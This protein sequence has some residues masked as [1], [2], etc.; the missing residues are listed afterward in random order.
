[1]VVKGGLSGELV[2]LSSRIQLTR[3]T[4][5]LPLI[6]CEAGYKSPVQSANPQS[7]EISTEC[8]KLKQKRTK[9]IQL[10]HML[11]KE[12]EALRDDTNNDC[13]GH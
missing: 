10:Y 6:L 8:Q 11:Y 12:P 7:R 5:A 13:A 4:A 3:A 2:S 1:M 9:W